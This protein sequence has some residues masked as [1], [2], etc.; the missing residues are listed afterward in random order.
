[1]DEPARSPAIGHAATRRARR[2]SVVWLIPLLAV[3]IG[4]WLA[5]TTLSKQ[6]PKITISFESGE[7]L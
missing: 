6:G 5:W 2:V 4:G 1:M 3:G 7:G